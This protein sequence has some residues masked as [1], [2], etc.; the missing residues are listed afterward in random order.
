[1]GIRDFHVT[2]VQTCAL[3]ICSRPSPRPPRCRPGSGRS[4][5]CALRTTTARAYASTARCR[6]GRPGGTT[7]APEAR[8]SAPEVADRGEV[9]AA[10]VV[11]ALDAV[12]DEAVAAVEPARALR[13]LEDPQRHGRARGN[14]AE[15]RAHEV[16]RDAAPPRLRV[17]VDGVDLQVAR[18]GVLVPA[19]A[20]RGEADRAA[21]GVGE[22]RAGAGGRQALHPVL[23][24]L[25][26][27]ERGQVLV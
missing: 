6:T 14:L 18:L 23:L 21:V 20:Q 15:H 1:D 11:A 5:W 2:G 24:A 7:S 4:A 25:V 8:V 12:G 9:L 10:D 13:V 26:V 16:A 19:R 17:E 22:P 27:V 3:P